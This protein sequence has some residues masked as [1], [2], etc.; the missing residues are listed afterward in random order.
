[1]IEG[2]NT[3]LS[4]FLGPLAQ[5]SVVPLV[6]NSQFTSLS[7]VLEAN[8]GGFTP[9]KIPERRE[10]LLCRVRVRMFQ[11]LALCYQECSSRGCKESKRDRGFVSVLSW[12]R[13]TGCGI[14]V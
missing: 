3:N 1:L 11:H 5:I 14:D 8:W 4:V 13:Q 7:S 9:S 10:E 2:I 6:P 12:E